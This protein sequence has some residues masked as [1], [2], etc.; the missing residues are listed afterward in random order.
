MRD[1]DKISA[2]GRG[3]LTWSEREALRVQGRIRDQ[4]VS[5]AQFEERNRR[6]LMT[7][8]ALKAPRRCSY[9]V[10]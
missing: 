9:T 1:K 2:E 8:M 3:V 4:A 5:H 7:D 6:S 10:K